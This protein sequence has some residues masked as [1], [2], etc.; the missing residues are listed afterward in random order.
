[1]AQSGHDPNLHRQCRL[2]RKDRV[3]YRS[4]VHASGFHFDGL[5]LAHMPADH[6]PIHLDWAVRSYVE[7]KQKAMN[8]S[9]PAKT[10]ATPGRAVI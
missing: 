2:Y 4:D 1:M 10:R 9:K 5:R 7:R 3:T 8:C 6:C